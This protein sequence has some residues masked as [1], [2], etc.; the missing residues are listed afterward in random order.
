MKHSPHIR[1]HVDPIFQKELEQ[2]PWSVPIA[3][4]HSHGV[5]TLNIKRG[6]S[7]HVVI[8]V[9]TGRFSFG[10]K[11][12]S[13]DISRKEIDNY[14]QLLLKGIHTLIPAGCVVREEQPI[15]IE[16]PIGIQYEENFIAHTVTVLVQNVL[17]DS[18]L[19]SRNFRKENRQK[20]WDAIVQL[21]VQLHIN[22]V[23]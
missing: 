13:E 22:G 1:F 12:I 3:D 11:E 21:F 8:F 2:L 23:Y 18:L 9:K 17:P 16:T 15:P 7:R 14:E 20:I 19:Y 6:I 4:W 10:I 5:N